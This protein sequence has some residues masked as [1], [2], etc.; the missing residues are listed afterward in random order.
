MVAG[1][2]QRAQFSFQRRDQ[3]A[4]LRLLAPRVVTSAPPKEKAGEEYGQTGASSSPEL[5][6]PYLENLKLQ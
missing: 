5:P 1:E 4:A 2:R 6:H 3:D